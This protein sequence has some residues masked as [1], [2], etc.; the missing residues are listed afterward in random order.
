MHNKL[1]GVAI[2]VSVAGGVVIVSI[3]GKSGSTTSDNQVV[4]INGLNNLMFI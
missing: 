2:G 3:P 1:T 4:L